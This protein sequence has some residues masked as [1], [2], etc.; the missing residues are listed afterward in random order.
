MSGEGRQIEIP[1]EPGLIRSVVP[2][3]RVNLPMEAKATD[4]LLWVGFA[5]ALIVLV[6]LLMTALLGGAAFRSTTP[7]AFLAL[8]GLAGLSGLFALHLGSAVAVGFIDANRTG[9]VLSV[10]RQ[11]LLDLRFSRDIIPWS[12]ITHADTITNG[13]FVTSGI[14]LEFRTARD[15][16]RPIFRLGTV[17][18]PVWLPGRSRQKNELNLSVAHLSIRAHVLGETILAMVRANGGKV[19]QISPLTGKRIDGT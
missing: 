3:V 8:M 14:V 4:R 15:G 16:F 2:P 11:G 5:Y 19:G 6:L 10:S 9:V 12:D 18:N 13:S 7:V 17:C 1:G